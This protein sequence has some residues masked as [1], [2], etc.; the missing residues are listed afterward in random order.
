MLYYL[1]QNIHVKKV[2]NLK[3]T[4]KTLKCGNIRNVLKRCEKRSLAVRVKQ[5]NFLHSVVLSAVHMYYSFT[6]LH[7][8]QYTFVHLCPKMCH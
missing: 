5:R 2:E 3:K 1:S 6:I 8:P 7:W 4:L